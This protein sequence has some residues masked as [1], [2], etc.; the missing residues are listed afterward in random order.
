MI[1]HLKLIICIPFLKGQLQELTPH[2]A[3]PV[4]G[5]LSIQ[6]MTL[7][8]YT[9]CL[10]SL[11]VA[12]EVFQSQSKKQNSP[13][14]ENLHGQEKANQHSGG[15]FFGE[16]SAIAKANGDHNC[17]RNRFIDWNRR[18][19]IC[20]L[21]NF[22]PLVMAWSDFVAKIQHAKNH[23]AR[24][25]WFGLRIKETKPKAGEIVYYSLSWRFNHRST[26]KS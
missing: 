19:G 8:N 13:K 23:H 17:L 2:S 6:R 16:P 5:T 1:N 14:S 15:E 4:S 11:R 24:F 25:S 3:S 10:Q 22:L 12:R 26:P 18:I 7:V 20:K 21:Q 9:I